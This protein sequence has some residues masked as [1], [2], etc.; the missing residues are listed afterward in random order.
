[1]LTPSLIPLPWFFTVVLCLYVPPW[2]CSYGG[3]RFHYCT[4][5]I[6][7]SQSKFAMAIH[8]EVEYA[9]R[10]Q[11]GDGEGGGKPGLGLDDPD[12]DGGGSED[13]DEGQDGDGGGKEDA[14]PSPLPPKADV[15]WAH[16]L[17]QNQVGWCVCCFGSCFLSAGIE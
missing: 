8:L 17:A 11:G 16:I 9:K 13:G 15:S 12:K 10:F 2:L 14:T 5:A 3:S 4:V 1:M 7:L 6:A